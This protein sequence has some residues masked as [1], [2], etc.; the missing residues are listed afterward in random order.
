MRGDRKIT[1]RKDVIFSLVMS[2]ITVINYNGYEDHFFLS[3]F[4]FVKDSLLF[5]SF[6]LLFYISLKILRMISASSIWE[7]PVREQRKHSVIVGALIMWVLWLPYLLILA[8]GL[9]NYDTIN[10][11]NDVFDGVSPVPFGFVEGQETVTAFLN[12]HHPVAISLLFAAF[13]KLGIIL[14]SA[15][16]GLFIYCL[17]QSFVAAVVISGILYYFEEKSRSKK[18]LYTIW[19]VRLFFMFMPFIPY[20]MIC[21]LKNTVH[22]LVFVVFV[23]CYYLYLDADELDTKRFIIS[24]FILSVLMCITQNTGVY[25]VLFTCLIHVIFNKKNRKIYLADICL[26][27]VLWFI[28]VPKVIYPAAQIYPGGKQEMLGTCFQQTARLIRDKEEELTAE[29]KEIINRVL[30]YDRIKE[31]Y[32]T[33]TTDPVKATYKLNSS[34]EDLKAYLVFWLKKGIRHP[35][36]YLRAVLPIC[37]NFFAPVSSVQIFDSIP[38]SEGVFN[39]VRQTN[40]SKLWMGLN[41]WYYVLR[42]LP[43]ISLFFQVVLYAF[44][45]PVY[46]FYFYVIT[47]KQRSDTVWIF[48]PLFIYILMLVV[49][50][51]DYTRYALPLLFGSP[52]A[53][54]IF[55]LTDDKNS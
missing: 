33:S 25:A 51:M 47:R 53:L 31:E 12:A 36:I 28:I 29:D 14:G 5:L 18:S 48:T 54:C 30:D 10:Q 20:Y 11:V 52:I 2:L 49:S 40:A 35:V 4:I 27:I 26:C 38:G 15:G 43:G 1:D 37:G 34:S 41:S 46:L 16:K 7:K 9:M 21:M 23:F 19:G 50:P 32:D 45:I 22:S 6:I 39:E 24:F 17:F 8:P 3:G 55:L 13:I 44:W 42:D